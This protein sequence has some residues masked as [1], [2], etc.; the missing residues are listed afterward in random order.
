M[1]RAEPYR[2]FFPLATL[3]GISGVSLWP[4]FFSGL[5]KFY[6]GPMHARMMIEGF[7]GGFVIG[8]LGTAVPRLL[9]APALRG[10]ELWS[11]VFLHLLAT[12]LHIG[13]Q[14]VA[15]DFIFAALLILLA[16]FLLQRLRRRLE[17][18]PPSFVLVGLGYLSG[19]TGALL[20]ACGNRGWVS[21]T[22]LFIGLGWLNEAFLFLLVLGVG[23][24]LLPRF[25]RIPGIRPMDEERKMTPAWRKR[26]L[27][28]LGV[29][30]VFLASYWFQY[31][32]DA[33]VAPIVARATA[34]IVFLLVMVPVH[35]GRGWG[36]AVS[37]AVL[38]SIVALLLGLALPVLGPIHRIA[39]MHMIFLAGFSLITFTVATRV[40][41]GHSGNRHLLDTPLI[42]LRITTALLVIGAILRVWGD[43]SQYHVTAL[44]AAS[45]LWMI[46]AGIW[47]WAV[48]PKV[49]QA[50][51]GH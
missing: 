28:S 50:G 1:C 24:F 11:L 5:H 39:A 45:Y 44:N 14:M 16:V 23:G 12:G 10:W 3:V 22:W 17:L 46:A 31:T 15:G 19:L 9:S 35:R 25:L 29:G 48:L 34:A 47:G 43:G 30:V 20:A 40:V 18:P 7:L 4:L 36:R 51:E 42:S 26:A 37:Q 49:R 13:H 21:P 32:R 2:I 6:P 33:G 38:I 27:F 8:F 41:L